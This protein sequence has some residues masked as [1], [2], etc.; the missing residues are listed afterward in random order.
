VELFYSNDNTLSHSYSPTIGSGFPEDLRLQVPGGHDDLFIS[1]LS[2]EVRREY[3]LSSGTVVSP[4]ARIGVDFN[5]GRPGHGDIVNG[6][7]EIVSTEPGTGNI[8][9]GVDVA[10]TNGSRLEA[11]VGYGG[12]GEED[13]D[14]YGGQIAFTIPF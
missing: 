5:L 2:T 11:R 14:K 4:Y 3:Q 9:A 6:D 12:I 7:L 10:F 1:T 8:L 13:L